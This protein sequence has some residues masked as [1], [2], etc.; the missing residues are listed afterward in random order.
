MQ[1][2]HTR[3]ESGSRLR[4]DVRSESAESVESSTVRAQ[5]LPSSFDRR[6][7]DIVRFLRFDR[8]QV[9][10]RVS[11][12]RRDRLTNR[13]RRLLNNR[14]RHH[15]FVSSVFDL[16]ERR[17]S[18]GIRKVVSEFVERIDCLNDALFNFGLCKH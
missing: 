15:R 3:V 11:F 5:R 17:H 9:N 2:D 10:P 14:E 16:S 6:R 8:S 7:R 18:T 4:S 12:L 13:R 1:P